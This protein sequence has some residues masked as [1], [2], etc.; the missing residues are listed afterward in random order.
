MRPI[1]GVLPLYNAENQ[2]FW[3]NPLYMG[4][5]EQAGGIP[6][7]LSLSADPQMWEHYLEVCDG[8]VF[9]GG[10]DIDPAIYG[11]EKLPECGYQAEPRDS[12][13][14]YMI[15]RL[16][17][18]DK[19]ALGICRG[20][21][22][23]NAALGG[24]LYQ[25]IFTQLSTG[26]V[27]RQD[28]PYDIPHHQVRLQEGTKIRKIIGHEVLSVNSMHHQAVWKP[29][30]GFVVSATAPDGMIEAIEH[31]EKRFLVGVQ[32]HPEHMW[33]DYDSARRLWKAF[34]S[35]CVQ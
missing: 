35:A 11:Q 1:I 12:Q 20:I 13:E 33:Q 18:L 31:P 28:K 16:L 34:V 24:T 14:V 17:E 3:I 15:R 26:V 19:P 27:H 6:M 30:P 32:W 2:T 9:T 5:V 10:Q 4:G 21:Q 7:L 8:F 22:I 23:M 29:A 25:D